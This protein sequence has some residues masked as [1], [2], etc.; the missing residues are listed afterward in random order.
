MAPHPKPFFVDVDSGPLGRRFALLHEPHSA[1]PRALVVYVHPFAEEMNKS[2]RMAAMQSRAL[3]QAG[4][5]V[6]QLDLLGCGDSAGDFGDASWASW[7]ADVVEACAWLRSRYSAP[8]WLWGLRAGCLL[9]VDAARQMKD[10]CH[11]LFW[12]PA[13]A[14]KPLL[15]QFL[16]LKTAGLLRDGGGR[17]IMDALKADLAAD[18]SVH[19]AGYWINPAL[20]RGLDAAQLVPPDQSDELPQSDGE[21]RVVWLELSN[22]DD[23]TLSP[24]AIA[25]QTKWRGSG[26]TV[27][28]AVIPGPPFWQTTEIE[29]AP[30][31]VTASV[32]GLVGTTAP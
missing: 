23:A 5:A 14:G 28:T 11:F 20:A 10:R 3:A 22:R 17:A 6:L 25:V 15:Q 8:L 9:A 26:Y 13:T 24:A 4:C 12:Q 32:D 7:V 19:I 2:R 27:N 16:R 21:G 18:R 31:L 30:A 29:T 1:T